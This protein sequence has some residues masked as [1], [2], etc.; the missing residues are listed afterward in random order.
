[1]YQVGDFVEFLPSSYFSRTDCYHCKKRHTVEKV[2]KVLPVTLYIEGCP[3]G[4]NHN[5]F[6]LA[7]AVAPTLAPTLAPVAVD[8]KPVIQDGSG[9]CGPCGGYGKHKLG[10]PV[11]KA[12]VS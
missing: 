10:C 7:A 4:Y 6:K 3:S 8:Q 2:T 9:Y 5:H 1:M 11:T 12:V